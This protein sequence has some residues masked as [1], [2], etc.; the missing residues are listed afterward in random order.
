MSLQTTLNDDI[1]PAMK[2]K[3]KE[4]LAV[5][6]MLKTAIQNDQ[7]KAGRELNGEEELTVLSREMKQRK[8]SLSE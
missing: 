1:K 8:D 4:T 3:D 7:I 2:A 6:R 5:L